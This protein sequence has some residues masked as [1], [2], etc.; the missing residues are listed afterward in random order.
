MNENDIGTIIIDCAVQLHKITG[1]GLFESVYEVL[2]AKM[3]E[4]HGLQV[5][6]QVTIPIQFKGINFKE[7]FRADVIVEKKVILELKSI[8]KI[9]PAHNKQLLTYLKLSNLKLGYLLN[10][11]APLMKEGITRMIN[12]TL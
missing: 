5:D 4:E 6:R 1:P 7:G 9:C 3:I 2:L 11:G 10:F 8:E 12:G